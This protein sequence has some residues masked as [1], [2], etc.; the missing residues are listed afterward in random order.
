MNQ[1]RYS[2]F[3]LGGLA[4]LA[5]AVVGIAIY[6]SH[7]GGNFYIIGWDELEHR[8]FADLLLNGGTGS[9]VL[10]ALQGEALTGSAAGGPVWSS[11]YALTSSGRT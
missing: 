4:S 1:V 8:S 6:A 2:V 9:F 3:T 5:A 11:P 7:P 10:N